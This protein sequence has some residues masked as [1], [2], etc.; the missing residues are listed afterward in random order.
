MRAREKERKDKRSKREMCKKEKEL[1]FES[2][3]LL[4]KKEET[5]DR[6]GMQINPLQI[7]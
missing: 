5:T 7:K 4:E 2:L 1:L 6:D 3:D